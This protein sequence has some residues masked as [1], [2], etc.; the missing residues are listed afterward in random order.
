MRTLRS[1]G[2][3]ET[4]YDEDV[5][6]FSSHREAPFFITPVALFIVRAWLPNTLYALCCKLHFKTSTRSGLQ[7][8]RN[9]IRRDECLY[10]C[11]KRICPGA[12]AAVGTLQIDTC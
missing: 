12:A 4:R 7:F 6:V 5:F 8:D 2:T 1:E 11:E 9:D 10:V 3:T